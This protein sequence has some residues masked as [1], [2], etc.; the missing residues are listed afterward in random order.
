MTNALNILVVEDSPDDAD[1]MLR[2]LRH[3]GFDPAWKRVQEEAE[4]L[5]EIKKMPDI[6]LSDYALPR[7]TGLRAVKLLRESGLK[8]PFILVSGTVGEDIAVEAM[9]YGA[10]DYLLKDRVARLGSAVRR[11]LDEQQLC[12]HRQRAEDELRESEE[13]FRQLAENINEVFWMTPPDN[14]EMLYISPAFEKIWGR[15]CD[16]LYESPQSW[17]DAIHT[18]DRRRVLDASRTKQERGDYDETYRIVRPDGTLRWIR[19]RAFPVRDGEGKIYRI[20]G[21]AEDITERLKMEAKFIEAQKMEVVGQL[22]GGVAH[23]FNNIIAIIM[24]YSDLTMEKLPPNDPM[25]GNLET[26]HHTAERAAALTRQLLVFSRNQT[27]QPVVLDLND[28]LKEITKMLQRLIGEHIIMTIV[29]GKRLAR[30]KADAGYLGQLLMN[31]VVNARDAMPNG[32]K[33]IIETSNATLDAHYARTHKGVAAGE[34]VLLS[35]SDTGTGMTDEVKARMFDAFFTTKPKG[36]GTGLGLATCQT[37]VQESGG[38]IAV[39]S[40]V[41][42]GTTF[43]VYFPQVEGLLDA[44]A[45]QTQAGPLPR[46]TETV[47]IVEDEPSLRHLARDILQAQGYEVLRASNGLHAMFVAR[48]HKGS[49]IRLVITDVIMPQMGGK[50]MAEWLQTTYPDIKILF[51]SGY[52]D[53]AIAHHGMLESGVDFLPKPYTPA[54]LVGKVREML[55]AN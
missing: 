39:D 44:D 26:I 6:I 20:V 9:K 28:E 31:L 8:I 25:R 38:H 49:P 23:D 22:A 16:S 15:T 35:V 42:K 14:H 45:R 34:Y 52:T 54:A 4:F 29:P 19:D 27:V 47:L 53:D 10:T 40:E 2:E 11:A 3:A 55:D 37:I 13:K 33:L 50:V 36:K 21:T 46:G 32:G 48:E 17:F 43:R 51:T 41:G 5:A 1:L 18:D 24:G 30:I 12:R 7:F